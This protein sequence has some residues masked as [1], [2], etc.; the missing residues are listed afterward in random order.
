MY[1]QI[2]QMVMNLIFYSGK[3]FAPQVP[4]LKSNLLVEN[5]WGGRLQIFIISSVIVTIVD[6]VDLGSYEEAD[7]DQAGYPNISKMLWDISI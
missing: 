6:I 2:P 1:V 5:V 3:D 7:F 4:A